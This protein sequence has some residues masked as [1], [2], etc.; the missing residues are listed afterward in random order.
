MTKAGAAV[1]TA[2]L[3][4]DLHVNPVKLAGRGIIIPT[5]QMKR[6]RLRRRQVI[7][8]RWQRCIPTPGFPSLAP[9][10]FLLPSSLL[11]HLGPD[12]DH[13]VA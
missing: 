1:Y 3:V 4:S 11:P 2:G 12:E 6:W 8:Q 10:H 7:C 9:G 5:L 13:M